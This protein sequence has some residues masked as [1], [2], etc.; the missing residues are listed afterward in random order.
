MSTKTKRMKFT[1]NPMFPRCIIR[2]LQI[3]ENGKNKLV[4]LKCSRDIM[5]QARKWISRGTESMEPELEG[6]KPWMLNRTKTKCSA[7]ICSNSLQRQEVKEI[8][9]KLPGKERS[10]PGLGIGMTID[11]CHRSGKK[12]RCV[13]PIEET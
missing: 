7:T 4:V 2:L 1:Q 13:N 10:L 6:D 12:F 8:G 9:R 3:K 11:W 5:L